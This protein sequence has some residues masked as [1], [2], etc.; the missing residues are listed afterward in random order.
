MNTVFSS[1]QI[2][3]SEASRLGINGPWITKSYLEMILESKGT[4]MC[5]ADFY[6]CKF[7]SSFCP[8]NYWLLGVPRLNSPPPASSNLLVGNQ[9][10]VLS[11]PRPIRLPS[12]ALPKIEDVTQPWTRSPTKS[13]MEPVLPRWH[14][15][16]GFS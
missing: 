15:I 9:N 11:L 5:W 8:N 3:G 10:R 4:C 12:S 6:I 16:S 13:D 14:F 1:F 2:I 7:L